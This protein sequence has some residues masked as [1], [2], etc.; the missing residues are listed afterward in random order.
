MGFRVF[1]L[2]YRNPQSVTAV[3]TILYPFLTPL[4]VSIILCTFFVCLLLIFINGAKF[5]QDNPTFRIVAISLLSVLSESFPTKWFTYNI[6]HYVRIILF[7]WLP[8]S[9]LLGCVYKSSLLQ[10]LVA[11]ELEDPPDTFHK[12]MDRDLVVLVPT[13]TML[14]RLFRESPFEHI[15]LA[16]EHGV[17]KN[18]F[19][20]FRTGPPSWLIKAREEGRAVNFASDVSN[21]G[22]RHQRQ[23]S[24]KELPIGYML[25]GYIFKRNSLLLSKM[26][27]IL[28]TLN[29]AGVIEYLNNIFLWHKAKSERDHERLNIQTNLVVLTWEHV[30]WTFLLVSCSGLSI[31]SLFFI[32]ECLINFKSNKIWI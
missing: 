1:Y 4:W 25:H 31:S 8:M 3:W 9:F 19:F 11:G 17:E 22:S 20:P 16:Y 18:G 32:V 23:M 24:K 29:E 13:G 26:Q 5:K 12:V 27:P 2:T 28:M 15:K 10:F 14:E 7:F 30:G 6:S 21:V